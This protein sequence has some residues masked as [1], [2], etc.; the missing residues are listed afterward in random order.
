M[1]RRL[2]EEE[3]VFTAA[4]DRCDEAIRG[5]AGW[6]VLQEL[7]ADE[8]RS[9]LDQV[10][11]IQPCIFAV[12]VALSAL[13]RS[14]GI[15]PDAVIGHSMGEAAAACVAGALSL[16]DAARVICCRSRLVKQA[17]GR[18]AMAVVELAGAEVDEAIADL[19]PRV[20][21]AAMNAGIGRAGCDSG[22]DLTDGVAAGVLP[23]SEGRLRVA[24]PADGCAPRRAL[25]RA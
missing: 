25:S 6:S 13:W 22:A 20:S 17:S 5:V 21:V 9:R 8:G 14:F 18:G 24:R 23:A 11:V 1:G 3:P 16:D 4:L 15:E 19:A 7:T 10:D 2:A 12:Q